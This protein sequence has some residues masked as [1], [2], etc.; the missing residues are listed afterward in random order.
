MKF[1][2][3]NRERFDGDENEGE[4]KSEVVAGDEARFASNCREEVRLDKQGAFS[5]LGRFS[6]VGS[7]GL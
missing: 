2:D 4:E 7:V 6:D 5:W 1:C 3:K